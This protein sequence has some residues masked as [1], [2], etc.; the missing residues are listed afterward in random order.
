MAAL[1]D[2]LENDDLV[3]MFLYGSPGTRK[4]WWA[5]RAAEAGFNVILADI[6]HGHKILKQL[7]P[8]A[9]KRI[10]HIDMRAPDDGYGNSGSAALA[11]AMNGTVTFFDEETRK[12]VGRTKLDP[13]RK[14]VQLDFSRLTNRDI[15]IVDSWTAKVQQ[16]GLLNQ[17]I[18]DPTKL[19]K[20]EWDDYA[21]M[22][23]VLDHFLSGVKKCNGHV[24]VIGHTD[25][26]AKRKKDASEKAKPED[27]IEQ[28]RT[29]PY[30][31]T[32]AH[33][34]TM[35]AN[36]SDVLHFEINSS[37]VGTMIT[38]KG[39]ADFD[40]KSRSMA[41]ITASF[42]KLRF[43]QFVSQTN[44]DLVKD[45]PVYS[46]QAAKEVMGSDVIAAIEANKGSADIKVGGITTL[47]I[48]GNKS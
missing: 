46:S 35:A 39:D 17:V 19:S 45:N 44:L 37:M 32:R 48:G 42:E 41:P 23:L 11:Y 47:K 33:A 22:R 14:Y 25:T 8:E 4:T 31:V 21:K 18:V 24:I 2:A 16:L 30:S 6:D 29:Q 5:G 3:R 28:I 7:S 1:D 20:F 9:R 27:A 34:E 38:T 10:F 26:Y 15:L 43:E 12:F 36:F 13:A 40:A